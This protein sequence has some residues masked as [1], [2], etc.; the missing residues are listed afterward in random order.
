MFPGKEHVGFLQIY[1]VLLNIVCAGFHIQVNL[2]GGGQW[3]TP[4]PHLYLRTAISKF[5]KFFSGSYH[6]VDYSNHLASLATTESIIIAS[7][8]YC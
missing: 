8:S 1:S 4:K 5:Q 7:Y 3:V 2:L 6:K